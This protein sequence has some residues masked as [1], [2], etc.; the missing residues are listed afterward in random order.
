MKSM[1]CRIFTLSLALAAIALNAMA[2]SPANAAPERG[3][4]SIETFQGNLNSTD[5]LFKLDSNVGY[6]FNK[7]FGVFAGMPVYFDSVS[8]SSSTT[9]G[10]TTGTTSSAGGGN[11]IG[12]VYL[13]FGL[14]FPSDVLSYESTVTAGAPTGSTKNGLSSGRASVDWGNHFDLSIGHFLPFLDA[15]LG[16]T[17]PDTKLVTRAF[18]SLGTVA[19]FEEGSEYQLSRYFAVGGSAYHVVPFGNQKVF[20]KVNKSGQGNGGGAVASNSGKGKHGVFQDQFFSSGTGLTEENGASA[21]VA[22]QPEKAFWRAQAGYTHSL[23]YALNSF[24][25]NLGLNIGKM[26]RARKGP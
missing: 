9:T 3:F 15:G 7:H 4:T 1:I 17:V 18:T 21:W 19:H 26:M 25:F 10:T 11:G 6:D 23:T 24:T 14:R 22:V 13:G 5:R 2:Q 8:Q 16:N 20:S 12:N